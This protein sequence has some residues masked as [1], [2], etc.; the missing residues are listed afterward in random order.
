[1]PERHLERGAVELPAAPARAVSGKRA[2]AAKTRY[3]FFLLSALAVL[4]AA[5]DSTIVAVAIPQLTDALNA[6]LTWVAWTLTAY[7]LVQVVMLPLAGKLSDSLGRKR[8]FMFCVGSFTFGSLL[9]GLAPSIGFLILFRAL[10][11]LGGGGLMPSAVGIVSDEFKERRAQAIGLFTSVFPIGGIIGPNLGGFILHNWSW[12]ELFFI[13]VPIGLVVMVG[14]QRL[15]AS[16]P[17]AERRVRLDFKGLALF[18]AAMVA[19][20]YGMTEL[21]NNPEAAGSPLLWALFVGS[22]LLFGL[23]LLHIRSAPEP[24]VD[25]QL[26]VRN[27][28]LAANLYN[29]LYGAAAF[30]FFSFVPY[31]AVARYGMTPF[32]SG[33]VL[34]P[35]AL[36]M[37]AVSTLASLFVIRLGYRLPMLLGMFLVVISLLLLSEGWGSLPIDGVTISAFWVMAVI[38]TISGIG[39]GFSAP[40][41]N[42]AALDLAPGKAAA[43]TG[44]RGMFRQT[45]GVIAIGAI[46]LALSF[47]PD[48]AQGMSVIFRVLAGILLLTVPLT[49][50][51]PDTARERYLRERQ[52]LQ[53]AAGARPR[54]VLPPT[55]R[56]H[57]ESPPGS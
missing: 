30:G 19:L 1:M 55:E 35:R 10:Q 17:P 47:F 15:L 20:L 12:R 2:P 38:V 16:S 56:A 37:L 49:W 9:C 51:I 31:Y 22:V 39:M 52:R 40:A 4:M 25:Y 41:S 50:M 45:G 27:P 42:N 7:Q 28:F 3:A 26:L 23:F 24:M 57:L 6:P 53:R 54:P 46:V 36:A 43:L 29:F 44:L 48:R 8:V 32:E 11:A 5:I 34:T 14:V 33:A 21:G 18:A 13:N